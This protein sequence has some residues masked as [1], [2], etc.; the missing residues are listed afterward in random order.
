[1]FIATLLGYLPC[2]MAVDSFPNYAGLLV[3]MAAAALFAFLL[4]V[5]VDSD[6]IDPL[7]RLFGRIWKTDKLGTIAAVPGKSS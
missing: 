2:G 1:M 6:K 7:T 4:S 5:P 3:G